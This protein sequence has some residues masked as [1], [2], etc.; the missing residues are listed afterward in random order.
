MEGGEI[1]PWGLEGRRK[2]STPNHTAP[3]EQGLGLLRGPL[4]SG[5]TKNNHYLP[6]WAMH[7]V[8]TQGVQELSEKL[9]PLIFQKLIMPPRPHP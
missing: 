6:G 2:R 7:M 3:L 9:L 5:Y 1:T 4:R 8:K